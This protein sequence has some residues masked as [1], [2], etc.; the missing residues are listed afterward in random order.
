G[1]SE[2]V[3]APLWTP[4]VSLWMGVVAV[5]GWVVDVLPA[6]DIPARGGLHLSSPSCKVPTNLTE[7][8]VCS[9]PRA[10]PSGSTKTGR[11]GALQPSV[12]PPRI[13]P[14]PRQQLHHVPKPACPSRPHRCH[15]STRRRHRLNPHNLLHHQRHT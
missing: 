6:P 3:G 4:T 10:T 8:G 12:E 1:E 15:S 7:R 11:R 9:E 5:C 14:R 13:R 2:T